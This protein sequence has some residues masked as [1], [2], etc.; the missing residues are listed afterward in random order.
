LRLSTFKI[1]SLAVS[2]SPFSADQ[3]EVQIGARAITKHR[4][5]I[6]SRSTG[7]A[8]V[9]RQNLTG[10]VQAHP[11]RQ[12]ASEFPDHGNAIASLDARIASVG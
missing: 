6:Q 7:A 3:H 9:H 12:P 10:C 4:G 2:R 11:A 8:S 5:R 1:A